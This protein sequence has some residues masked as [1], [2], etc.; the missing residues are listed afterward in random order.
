MPKLFIAQPPNSTSG[1]LS[2]GADIG[3]AYR[4]LANTAGIAEQGLLNH[5]Q[6]AKYVRDRAAEALRVQ[7]VSSRV[8]NA[9]LEFQELK[10]QLRDETSDADEYQQLY[11][12][13]SPLI[14]E[15]AN[16]G[17]DKKS[18]DEIFPRIDSASRLSSI[19]VHGHVRG[20][21][22]DD[23]MS[24]LDE[25]GA[26][27]ALIV[28]RGSLAEAGEAM[29][30]YF[31]SIDAN[32]TTGLLSNVSAT[33][34]KQKFEEVA[35]K[36]RDEY[37]EGQ[38]VEGNVNSIMADRS[39]S[40]LQKREAT[41]HIGGTPEWRKKVLAEVGAQINAT[42]SLT[43]R[44]DKDESVYIMDQIDQDPAAITDDIIDK[45]P[46]LKKSS[47]IAAKAHRR[48][49]LS[50]VDRPTD[51]KTEASLLE[52]A[53]RDPQSFK[54]AN[55]FEEYKTLSNE[56]RKKW[57]LEQA[58]IHQRGIGAPHAGA[59]PIKVDGV[60]LAKRFAKSE[61]IDANRIP[62]F[63]SQYTREYE[64][65]I[66]ILRE[67]S[68]N[69]KA[70]LTSTQELEIVDFLIGQQVETI[71]WWPDRSF[72][73]GFLLDPAG[74][75]DAVENADIESWPQFWL[76]EATTFL[77]DSGRYN[78]DTIGNATD[79]QIREALIRAN[80]EDNTKEGRKVGIF[81]PNPAPRNF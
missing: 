48:D 40:D 52:W 69:P 47:V 72:Q 68:N 20:L 35:Q 59:D 66:V 13:R 8:T 80:T 12:E 77:I 15:R 9:Q 6:D 42:N 14:L 71:N 30:G 28:A 65:Q 64:R 81:A 2:G 36:Q 21:I 44:A 16:E 67:S 63:E 18:L 33:N 46:G 57:R 43:D 1:N 26:T 39:T 19:E 37:Q 24:K 31:A 78:F 49:I 38:F 10:I 22:I 61:G 4:Q 41:K 34:L 70:V 74:I 56:D 25:Q 50:G 73:K 5:L 27:A 45:H 53:R 79:A 7:D 75:T 58:S 17:L 60:N 76:D 3:S 32:V 54:S 55:I 23:A 29:L 62:F 51:Q 11:D